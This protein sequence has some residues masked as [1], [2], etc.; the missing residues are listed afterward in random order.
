MRTFLKVYHA[1]PFISSMRFQVF[2]VIQRKETEPVYDTRGRLT[3][4][5][6]TGETVTVMHLLGHGAIPLDAD[7]MA[8]AHGYQPWQ[9]VTGDLSTAQKNMAQ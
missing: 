8:Q 5:Q 6:E 9:P 1:Q 4:T 2:E 3:G 7:L